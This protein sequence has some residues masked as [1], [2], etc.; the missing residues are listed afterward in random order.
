MNWMRGSLIAIALVAVLG[1]AATFFVE[2][3][4]IGRVVE[5]QP[6]AKDSKSE[7]G[8]KLVGDRVALLNVPARAFVTQGS[9]GI[10]PQVDAQVLKESPDVVAYRPI[11]QTIG[12]ARWGALAAIVLVVV[13]LVALKRLGTSSPDIDDYIKSA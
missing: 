10:P 2:S 13:G 8:W 11:G 4:F 12:N 3:S 6:I 1:L 7:T 9:P 5:V